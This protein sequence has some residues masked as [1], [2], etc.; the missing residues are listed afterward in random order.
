M[1]EILL[2]VF[3]ISDKVPSV[4]VIYCWRYYEHCARHFDVTMKL[5]VY[6][7]CIMAADTAIKTWWRWARWAHNKSVITRLPFSSHRARWNDCI[8]LHVRFRLRNVLYETA[9]RPSRVNK[10]PQGNAI[11]SLRVTAQEHTLINNLLETPAILYNAYR[12]KLVGG[13]IEK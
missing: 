13:E 6:S 5:S 7:F 10:S 12:E 2:V 3:V 11:S 8:R 9:L 1:W 4:W